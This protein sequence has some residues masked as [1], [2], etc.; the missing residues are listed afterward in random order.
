MRVL[1]KAEKKEFERTYAFLDFYIGSFANQVENVSELRF[2]GLVANREILSFCKRMG[3]LKEFLEFGL[4]GY[5]FASLSE[6]KKINL[7]FNR[8]NAERKEIAL[9]KLIDYCFNYKV[10][11][12]MLRMKF[13][14]FTIAKNEIPTIF[15]YQGAA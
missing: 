1:T 3:N 6:V 13:D 2:D 5:K 11:P 10:Q 9:Q 12:H 7:I 15:E 4:E 14:K 8:V